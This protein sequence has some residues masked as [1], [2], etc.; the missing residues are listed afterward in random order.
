MQMSYS[1]RLDKAARQLADL[2]SAGLDAVFAG[3]AYSG[4]DAAG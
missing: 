3:E 4:R 2:E 1:G